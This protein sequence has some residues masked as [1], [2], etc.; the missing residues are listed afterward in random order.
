MTKYTCRCGCWFITEKDYKNHLKTHGPKP[1]KGLFEPRDPVLFPYSQSNPVLKLCKNSGEGTIW[2]YPGNR[3]K[4]AKLCDNCGMNPDKI[5]NN[6][7]P[8]SQP[9]TLEFGITTKNM[10]A[11]SE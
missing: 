11:G 1:V 4:Y 8:I 5:S 7:L 9:N 3:E 2:C 10:E 6:V